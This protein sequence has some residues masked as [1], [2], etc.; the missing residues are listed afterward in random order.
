MTPKCAV[1]GELMSL[2][3]DNNGSIQY[4]VIKF[5]TCLKTIPVY[6]TLHTAIS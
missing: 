6:K 1:P 2:F 3:L 4:N 5:V